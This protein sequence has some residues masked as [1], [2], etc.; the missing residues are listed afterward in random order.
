VP[1]SQPQALSVQIDRSLAKERMMA[2]MLGAF[3]LVALLLGAA[4]LYGVLGYMVARRTSEIGVR[5][6]LGATRGALL[7]SVLRES[8]LLVGAGV[9]IGV[10]AAVALSRLLTGLLFG[11]TPADPWVLGAGVSCL[12]LVGLAAAWVPAWRAS[13]VDPLVALRYE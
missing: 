2:R 12:L 5:L 11:V 13:R 1:V 6:A 10:P 9:A 4:G 3:A 8:S 7:W